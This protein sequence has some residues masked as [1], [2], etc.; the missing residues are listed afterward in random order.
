M[1]K[2]HYLHRKTPTKQKQECFEIQPASQVSSQ[3]EQRRPPIA[4]PSS[5]T[6]NPPQ[7]FAPLAS[8]PWFNQTPKPLQPK[9]PDQNQPKNPSNWRMRQPTQETKQRIERGGGRGMRRRTC[10]FVQC[11]R[12]ATISGRGNP[13]PV[14]A[15]A[16][17][18]CWWYLVTADCW[19]SAQSEKF[20]RRPII[21]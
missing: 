10:Y 5:P 7:R 13:G 3:S 2:I 14:W 17:R 19:G 18:L 11:R 9:I 8:R 15:V 12:P 16:G 20:A 6:T 4:D 21:G 1:N